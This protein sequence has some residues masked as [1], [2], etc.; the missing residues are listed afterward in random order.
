MW[1]TAIGWLYVLCSII[2]LTVHK[3]N[4]DKKRPSKPTT[5]IPVNKAP[6]A[7]LLDEPKMKK[8]RIQLSILAGTP[9]YTVTILMSTLTITKYQ[10]TSVTIEELLINANKRLITLPNKF[11]TK[12]RSMTDSINLGT[13]QASKVK[14]EEIKNRNIKAGESITKIKLGKTKL[15]KRAL[16]MSPLSLC[17]FSTS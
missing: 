6:N 4:F 11:L 7:I 1:D 14:S 15:G 9:L 3:V 2:W 8:I 16:Q 5:D 13:R 12:T 17:T 10:G